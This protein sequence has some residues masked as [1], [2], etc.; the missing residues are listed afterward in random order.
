M[1]NERFMKYR[2]DTA[3]DQTM[4]STSIAAQWLYVKLTAND[5]LTSAGVAPLVP[6]QFIHQAP[7]M[8]AELFWGCLDELE[9]QRL[10]IVDRE[11]GEVLVRS[12]MR[13]AK[14]MSVPNR[15]KNLVRV[16][17]PRVR[18]IHIRAA[19]IIELARL[20]R[21]APDLKAWAV[22]RAE[23]PELWSVVEEAGTDIRI[24]ARIP[25]L[26]RVTES[27]QMKQQFDMPTAPRHVDN[28]VE[29]LDEPPF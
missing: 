27:L 11:A 6:E 22:V 20:E 13:H 10:I 19:I 1:G 29:N 18:S 4:T 14:V 8:S 5:Y 16:S 7:D 25:V 17:W 26:E 28:P 21:D 23:A 9:A 24:S 3:H 12:Y 15:A 2:H